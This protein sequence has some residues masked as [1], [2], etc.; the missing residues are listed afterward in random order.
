MLSAA[1]L[2]RAA[3]EAER[4]GE[5]DRALRLYFGAGLLRLDRARAITLSPSLTTGQVSRRLRSDQFDELRE[6]FE[7]VAYGGRSAR[8][9]QVAAAR[10]GW[11]RVLAE[12]TR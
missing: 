8:G 9:E 4:L 5:L 6:A 7:A 1:E 11:P 2:E 3:G 10:E 12:V